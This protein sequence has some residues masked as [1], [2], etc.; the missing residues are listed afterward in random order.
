V[1]RGTLDVRATRITDEMRIAAAYAIARYAEELEAAVRKRRCGV[2]HQKLYK[3]RCTIGNCS[4]GVDFDD[5][6]TQKMRS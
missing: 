6:D 3:S 2:G 1:F 4:T 5:G